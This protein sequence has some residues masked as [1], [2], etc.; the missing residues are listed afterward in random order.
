[1]GGGYYNIR[2]FGGL[3]I[4]I[5]K[6]FKGNISDYQNHKYSLIIGVGFILILVLALSHI[7]RFIF[8]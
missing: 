6:L 8:N 5:F 3:I 7:D 4:W 2:I 1:M